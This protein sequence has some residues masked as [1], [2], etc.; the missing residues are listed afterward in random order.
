MIINVTSISMDVVRRVLNNNG[1][2]IVDMQFINT[3]VLRHNDTLDE[4]QDIIVV[5]K[6]GRIS[7]ISFDDVVEMIKAIK[8]N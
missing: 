6:E 3:G 1:Y 2:S 8:H 5:D 4:G 7:Q